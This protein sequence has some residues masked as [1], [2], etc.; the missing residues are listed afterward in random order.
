MLNYTYATENLTKTY[1]LLQLVQAVG[2]YIIE[3]NIFADFETK[4]AMRLG[5]DG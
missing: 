4:A 5:N 3:D 2:M 1:Q